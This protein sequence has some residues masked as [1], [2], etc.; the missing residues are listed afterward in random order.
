[1]LSVIKLG[2]AI[3]AGNCII[4][5][6]PPTAPCAIARFVEA[7]QTLV[8]PGVLSILHGGSELYAPFPTCDNLTCAYDAVFLFVSCSGQWI[9]EHPRILRVSMTGSTA[10]GKVVMRSAA[11]E[12]KSLT[13]ELGGNDPCI[14]LGDVDPKAMA[15][16]VHPSCRCISSDFEGVEGRSC[17]ARRTT[18]AR[19]ASR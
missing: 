19:R 1:M 8:P 9:V 17:W 2:Q 18:R 10:A 7:C 12:L 14:V 3:L 5:K 4:L 15:K 6:S 16:C 11:D 13:L